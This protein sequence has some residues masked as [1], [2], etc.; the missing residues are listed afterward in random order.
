[1]I[2][3]LNSDLL[4]IDKNSNKNVD[5]YYI[6][7]ITIKENLSI[8]SANPLCLFID[9]LDGHIKEKN[10]YKYWILASANNSKVVLIQYTE[11]WN[12]IKYLIQTTK[13]LKQVGM[14][15]S[16]WKS[17]SIQMKIYL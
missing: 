16:A 9:K 4:K 12:E 10:R 3:Y 11:H 8:H 5:I 2:K 15:K 14:K 13:A 1:M 6:G 7:Y 17:N